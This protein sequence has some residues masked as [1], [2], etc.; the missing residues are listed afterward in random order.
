[1][2]WKRKTLGF[3]LLG[4]LGGCTSEYQPETSLPDAGVPNPREIEST[5]Q[6]DRLVQTGTPKVDVLWVVDNSCSMQEEQDGIAEN[7]P[8]FLSFFQESGLDWH[9]GVVSTDMGD[10]LHAGKLRSQAG[11]RWVDPLTPSPESVLAAMTQM[12][13]GGSGR[14]KGRDAIYWALEVQNQHNF[15]FFRKDAPL[16]VIV[17]SDEDDD[18]V[19]IGENEFLDYMSGLRWGEDQL[20]FSSIVSED[21]VCPEATTAGVDYIRYTEE[22]GGIFWSVCDTAWATVL[23]QLGLQAVEQV[24]EYYLSHFP[25]PGT[26]EVTVQEGP[27]V[28][29]MTEWEDWTYDP[30]RNS[31]SFVEFVP[32]EGNIVEISYDIRTGEIP[33]EDDFPTEPPG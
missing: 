19:E 7:F 20:T 3:A 21:P 15:G 9:I 13:T 25:M 10:P 23:S 24:R 22:L 27:T 32:N 18:S 29:P 14:E 33:V 16:H 31:I 8:V 5:R 30:V 26:I 17:I 4:L 6:T 12:G 28:Y 1:M 2:G 11:H